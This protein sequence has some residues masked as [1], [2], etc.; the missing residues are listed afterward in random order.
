MMG[1]VCVYV[2][3]TFSDCMSTI[4]A[5]LSLD[6][7]RQCV[8]S[9]AT[10]EHTP[11]S[12]FGWECSCQVR[13]LQWDV[14]TYICAVSS[15]A[16]MSRTRSASAENCMQRRVQL[17]G[18]H[19]EAFETGATRQHCKRYCKHTLDVVTAT[20][21]AKLRDDSCRAHRRAAMCT[22]LHV[23]ND[24]SV[25]GLLLQHLAGAYIPAANAA[26]LTHC[27]A[28]LITVC[29]SRAVDAAFEQSILDDGMRLLATMG[30]T[31]A[32]TVH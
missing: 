24:A 14:T 6:D 29:E 28:H 22:R 10:C 7:V 25:D 1:R 8:P 9:G 13:N 32:W 20:T 26:V 2:R 21:A 3:I 18:T 15:A 12:G 11:C 30:N 4:L 17:A 23:S 5:V 31:W 19:L 27:D 16:R